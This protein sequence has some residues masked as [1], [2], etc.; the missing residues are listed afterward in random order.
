MTINH[1]IALALILLFAPA[2]AFAQPGVI[3]TS[4][5]G[6]WGSWNLDVGPYWSYLDAWDPP[7]DSYSEQ[8]TSYPATYPNGTDFNWSFPSNLNGSTNVYA[9]PLIVYGPFPGY[10]SAQS[11]PKLPTPFQIKSINKNFSVTFNVTLN[12]NP[13]GEDFLV[14]FW[15]STSTKPTTT[16]DLKAEVGFMFHN[17]DYD[18]NYLLSLPNPLRYTDSAGNHY[19]IVT[20]KQSPPFTV[21]TP[22]TSPSSKTPRDLADG[23]TH[24][25]PIGEVFSFLVS[26]GV[27]NGNDY[28]DGASNGF[29]IGRYS[30]SAVINRL[31]YNWPGQASHP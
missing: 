8:I 14:E 13:D 17:P 21:I 16:S 22:V 23:K 18:W 15:P 25:V 1:T 20:A 19:Y 29:E 5:D 6:Q 24:T 11:P 9:Y 27:L 28:I 2:L 30:G 7:S 12:A 31:S 26:K 3:N 4:N 10:A